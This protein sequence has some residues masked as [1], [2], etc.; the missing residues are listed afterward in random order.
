MNLGDNGECDAERAD[1]RTAAWQLYLESNGK[2]Y[3]EKSFDSGLENQRLS[4]SQNTFYRKMKVIVMKVVSES[5]IIARYYCYSQTARVC[6]RGRIAT[7]PV[8]HWK[9]ST[10][11]FPEKCAG[12]RKHL[13]A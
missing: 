11:K 3:P 5:R 2:L 6:F 8:L 4:F 7:L 12:Y 10:G 13:F 1:C 9:K